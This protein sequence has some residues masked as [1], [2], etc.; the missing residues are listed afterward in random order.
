MKLTIALHALAG[1]NWAKASGSN[2]F[3]TNPMAE[4]FI[5]NRR[6]RFEVYFISDI[7]EN[8]ANNLDLIDIERFNTV[9]RWENEYVG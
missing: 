1:G 8:V 6:G 9:H 3:S 2:V 7:L 4:V 5:I